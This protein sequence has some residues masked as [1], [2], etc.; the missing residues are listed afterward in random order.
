MGPSATRPPA[1]SSGLETTD[2]ARPSAVP[3]RGT[4][5]PRQV[6]LSEAARS[7][8]VSAGPEGSVPSRAWQAS[9]NFVPM[10]E[11]EDAW[12]LLNALGRPKPDLSETVPLLLPNACRRKTSNRADH[13]SAPSAKAPGLFRARQGGPAT[14]PQPQN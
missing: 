3:F 9:A 8:L 12:S 11:A 14:Q 1:G 5:V 13:V 10:C 7:R 4:C 6:Q 2:V